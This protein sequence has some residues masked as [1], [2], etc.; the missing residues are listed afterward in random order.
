VPFDSAP[1]MFVE[2]FPICDRLFDY[3]VA[4]NLELG[5]VGGSVLMISTRLVNVKA[6]FT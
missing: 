3:P 5:V 6:L 2:L 1:A 4:Y